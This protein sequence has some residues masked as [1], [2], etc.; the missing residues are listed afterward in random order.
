M[1]E[2][3]C[4]QA[5]IQDKT[6]GKMV[7]LFD[8]NGI[9]QTA[10]TMFYVAQDF[11][12]RGIAVIGPDTICVKSYENMNQPMRLSHNSQNNSINWRAIS[13]DITRDREPALRRPYP[14]L[15]H[16]VRRIALIISGG[17]YNSGQS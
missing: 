11:N 8:N 15:D 6:E 12:T 1:L 14:R 7:V 9:V 17:M 4:I 10:T 13:E 16:L 2:S 5:C 3:R